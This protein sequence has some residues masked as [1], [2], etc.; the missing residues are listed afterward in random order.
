ML[1]TLDFRPKRQYGMHG[2]RSDLPGLKLTS[3]GYDRHLREDEDLLYVTDRR[4]SPHR[5]SIVGA[6]LLLSRR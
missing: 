2:C 5:H 1:F 6:V 3:A 4:L